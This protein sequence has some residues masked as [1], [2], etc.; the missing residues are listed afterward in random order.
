[1]I[2]AARDGLGQHFGNPTLQDFLIIVPLVDDPASQHYH[3]DVSDALR[4]N[5]CTE[6]NDNNDMLS[7]IQKVDFVVNKV[8]QEYSSQGKV[9]G[10]SLYLAGHSAG[11]R[12]S[13]RYAI[14]YNEVSH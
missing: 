4:C 12:G 9:D 7:P 1:M 8:I 2:Q 11:C 10:N 13:I 5:P 3:P 6:G 14:S